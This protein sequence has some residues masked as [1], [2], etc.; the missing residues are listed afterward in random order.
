MLDSLKKNRET[1]TKSGRAAVAWKRKL[2]EDLL[3][4][5]AEK[6]TRCPIAAPIETTQVVVVEYEI[7]LVGQS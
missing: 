2:A 3:V 1:D 4:E 7:E 6:S 5:E